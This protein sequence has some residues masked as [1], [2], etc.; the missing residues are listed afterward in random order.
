LEIS[1]ERSCDESTIQ[2]GIL[3]TEDTESSSPEGIASGSEV[4]VKLVISRKAYERAQAI[5][6]EK[7][8]RE[9]PLGE[10]AGLMNVEDYLG[11][12]LEMHFE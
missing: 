12:I 6:A 3:M 11:Q 8:P 2:G 10:W 9:S 7:D 4:E 1:K 5:V